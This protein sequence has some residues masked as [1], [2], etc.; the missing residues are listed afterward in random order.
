MSGPSGPGGARPAGAGRWGPGS[1]AEKAGPQVLRGEGAVGQG[2]WVGGAPGAAAPREGR[3]GGGEGGARLPRVRFRGRG[4]RA[5]VRP[6]AADAAP[7]VREPGLW[8]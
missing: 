8:A 5:G 4:V 2:C 3:E 7:E 1:A 6:A